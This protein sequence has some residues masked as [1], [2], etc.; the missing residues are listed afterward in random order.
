[1]KGNT[2]QAVNPYLVGQGQSADRPIVTFPVE[3]VRARV[4]LHIGLLGEVNFT[5]DFVPVHAREGK[6]SEARSFGV[7]DLNHVKYAA[8]QARRW[9]KKAERN[10][11]ILRLLFWL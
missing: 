10:H 2:R 7:D 5:V 3:N 8:M 11:R 6:E 9:I 1:M 4:W